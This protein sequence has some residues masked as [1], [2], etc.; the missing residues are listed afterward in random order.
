MV[1]I[2]GS[3]V[4]P[5]RFMSQGVFRAFSLMGPAYQASVS[6]DGP[7][8]MGRL[9]SAHGRGFVRSFG[10]DQPPPQIPRSKIVK[11]HFASF[12]REL[13]GTV[14]IEDVEGVKGVIECATVRGLDAL[15]VTLTWRR[16]CFLFCL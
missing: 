5:R 11:M 8:S 3:T 16:R 2:D 15:A 13:H 7:C 9:R 6:K 4:Q 10:A 12:F 1:N 14:R